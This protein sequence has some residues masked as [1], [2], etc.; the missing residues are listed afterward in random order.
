MPTRIKL[1]ALREDDYG[2]VLCRYFEESEDAQRQIG[3]V[4]PPSVD[5]LKSIFPL[6][7]TYKAVDA[8]AKS[9]SIHGL[10]RIMS[11]PGKPGPKINVRFASDDPRLVRDVYPFVRELAKSELKLI[12]EAYNVFGYEKEK[13]ETLLDLGFVKG[14]ATL[15]TA[16]LDGRFYDTHYLYHSLEK[17][18]QAS[19]RKEYAEQGDLYPLLP[20]ERQKPPLKLSF[21]MATPDDGG[22]LAESIS[23]QNTFRTLGMG[24]YTGFVTKSESASFIEQG[25]K[26][27]LEHAI[28]CVDTDRNKV[29]GMSDV[30]IMLGHVSSHVGH[31]GIHVNPQYHGLGVGTGLL[32]EIDLLA[33]RLHLG[34]LV[35]SYFDNNEAG[36]KLYEKMGYERRGEVPGWLSSR[37]AKE[38]FMQK[39]L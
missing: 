21:R 26:S 1:S 36:R 27:G 19:P 2:T 14:A 10:V 25:K 11:R 37:Y 34:S 7:G 18:Y 16:C 22:D 15:N 20:V 12:V 33:K 17:D 8:T 6:A 5:D 32:K 28:V 24:T 9:G 4:L 31:V 39:M 30:G 29:I 38:I 3:F 23:H 35:L 13:I